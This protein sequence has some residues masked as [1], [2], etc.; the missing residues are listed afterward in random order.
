[1]SIITGYPSWYIIFCLLAGALFTWLLYRREQLLKDAGTWPGRL[2][3]TSRFVVISLLSFLLL[4]PMIRTITREVEKPIVLIAVD[5]SASIV[6]SKDSLQRKEQIMKDVRYL[7]DELGDEYDVRTLSFG[8]HVR[9]NPAFDFNPFAF[10][11][12]AID[13][14]RAI[15]S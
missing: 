13:T 10:T 11:C 6:N 14:A 4:G 12:F 2:L 8:D 15:S 3:I 5:E 9:E 1:M 7:R